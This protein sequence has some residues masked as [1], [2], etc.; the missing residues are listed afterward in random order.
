MKN[1][2]RNTSPPRRSLPAVA[3]DRVAWAIDSVRS[4]PPFHIH[5][6]LHFDRPLEPQRLRQAVTKLLNRFPLTGGTLN[7]NDLFSLRDRWQIEPVPDPD[8]IILPS[9]SKPTAFLPEEKDPA[10]IDFVNSRLDLTSQPPIRIL[11][12][13]GP[14]QSRMIIKSHHGFSDGK[15]L[16]FLLNEMRR[17][18]LDPADENAREPPPAEN[19][20]FFPRYLKAGI[21]R[22]PGI[23]FRL[24]S[25]AWASRHK[26]H[27]GQLLPSASAKPAALGHDS[28]LHWLNLF[29]PPDEALAIHN[30]ARRYEVKINDIILAAAVRT[31]FRSDLNPF[32]GEGNPEILM[33]VDLRGTFGHPAM[34]ANMS[35]IEI[36]SVP[37]SELGSF[38]QTVAEVKAQTSR[39]KSRNPG[40]PYLLPLACSRILPYPMVKGFFHWFGRRIHSPSHLRNGVTNLGII[41]PTLSDWGGAK[42]LRLSLLSPRIFPWGYTVTITSFN[43][44]IEMNLGF[45]SPYL[46]LESAQRLSQCFKNELLQ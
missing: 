14:N 44:S 37:R 5:A 36:I 6:F 19:R 30:R 16:L 22:W 41:D 38:P 1:L 15:G 2:S 3:F 20:G 33:A 21:H 10:V 25:L 23:L 11:F 43:G 13:S 9:R 4:F 26:F 18:Y 17:C 28:R 34:L 12:S 24:F 35:G 46:T 8:K 32:Q 39:I 45:L 31:F 29:F 7:I 27:P 42:L 40:L